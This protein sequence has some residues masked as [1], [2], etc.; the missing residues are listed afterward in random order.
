MNDRRSLIDLAERGRG[1]GWTREE[2]LLGLREAGASQADCVLVIMKLDGPGLGEAAAVIDNS[3]AWA[4]MR[5]VNIA[6]REAFWQA[7]DQVAE[8]SG[9]AVDY[10]EATGRCEV[11][12]RLDGLAGEDPL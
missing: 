3:E 12:V 4:D 7:L 11:K 2:L 5:G 8:D 10:D 6:V 1:K 9:G